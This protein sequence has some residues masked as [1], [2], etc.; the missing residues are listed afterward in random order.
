MAIIS[1]RNTLEW[2]IYLLVGTVAFMFLFAFFM[3]FMLY[4]IS[5]HIKFPLSIVAA[6]IILYALK[7]YLSLYVEDKSRLSILRQMYTLG[8]GWLVSAVY[9]SAIMVCLY[10]TGHYTITS[11]K[12]NFASQLAGL[13]FYLLV[14]VCEEVVFRGIVYRLISYKWNVVV[15]LIVSALLFGFLH[16]F[17][18]GATVWSSLAIAL[19]SGWFMGIAYAYHQ[20][21]WVPIGMHWGWNYLQGNI[22][23]CSVSGDA[24]V[25][26]PLFTPSISGPDILTGGTFGPEASIITFVIGIG[27]SIVYTVLY[28][29]K[30]KKL[31]AEPEMLF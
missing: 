26:N 27:I 29:K 14:G 8:I 16:I 21:I 10:F 1:K 4:D 25:Q 23:G 15:G 11:I 6:G 31:G 18:D 28:I 12:L 19:N 5:A 3:Q 30:K 7:K 2:G 22:F 20:T 17:N 13:S 24:A 9:F